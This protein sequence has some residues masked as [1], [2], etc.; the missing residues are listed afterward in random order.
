MM[1]IGTIWPPGVGPGLSVS[2][3]NGG[4]NVVGVGNVLAQPGINYQ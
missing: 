3:D 1:E 2:S 4:I